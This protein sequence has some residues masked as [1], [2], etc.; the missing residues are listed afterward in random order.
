M[1]EGQDSSRFQE[2]PDP[3]FGRM[4]RSLPVDRWL[5]PYDVRQSEAHASALER[6]GVLDRDELHRLR[7]ALE[8]VALEFADG[9]F[10]EQDADEDVHMAIER[11]LGELAGPVA[12]KLHTGRSRNDQVAT[13]LALAVLD[14]AGTTAELVVD[15][16]GALLDLAK[17]H[18]EW[19]MPGYTHLQRAQPVYLSHH[20]MAYF[21]M[22][23]RDRLRF[24]RARQAASVMPLGSG[25]LAG[26]NWDLD[27]ERL[28]RDL[29]FEACTPNSIDGA[30]NRDFALDF[31]SA[32][33]ICGT[34]LSRLGSELVIWSSAE[35]RFCRLSEPFTS[36]S[37][38]MP[39]KQN[40]DS[41]EI[42][43]AKAPIL[44][45]A[46]SGFA[47]VLHALPLTYNKDLQEDKRP[48]ADAI[49]AIAG[50]L[51]MATGMVKGIEFDRSRLAEAA[52]D[53]WLMATEIADLLVSKGVPFR[54]AHGIVGQM[55]SDC[56]ASDRLPS[57]LSTEELAAYSD[58]LAGGIAGILTP[59]GSVEAKRG[60]GATSGE[61]VARQLDEA[62]N[63]LATLD[64]GA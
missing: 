50:S 16:M 9:T 12:A 18:T 7:E 36:G 34:H 24:D 26:V 42:L 21:W 63:L 32:A 35:F 31:L 51:T 2:P 41:A 8:Q 47:G 55:V 28:A 6:L 11:R 44:T 4:N 37:S 61:E 52:S 1:R 29:G 39:Q 46:F 15:L 64:S 30:S 5:A 60:R 62:S 59:E 57:E 23:E 48:L 10:P 56:L 43:R 3:S 54:D 22:L 33:A 49:E 38:I 17:R 13:D 40:P 20:L 25:A 14:A 58:A 45:A 19:V 53:Q 27:R